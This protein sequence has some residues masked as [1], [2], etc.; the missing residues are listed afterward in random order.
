[1]EDDASSTKARKLTSIAGT[2]LAEV[3][4]AKF[5]AAWLLLVVVPGVLLGLAPLVLSAWLSR[6]TDKVATLSGLGSLAVLVLII[7]IGIHGLRPLLRLVERSFWALQAI[8]VQPIYALFREVLS[9]VT[10]SLL[11]ANADQLRRTQRRS[12]TALASGLLSSAVGIGLVLLVWSHTRWEGTFADLMAPV[13]LIIPALA[14]TVAIG[15]VYLAAASMLWAIADATMHQPQELEMAG[16]G[17]DHGKTWHIAHLS[18]LHTVGEPYGFRL[19]SGRAGPQGNSRLARVFEQLSRQEAQGRLDVVLI[20]GDMTDTGRSAEWIEFLDVLA[21]HRQLSERALILPGNH[22]VNVV[23]RSNPARLELPTSPMKQLRQMRTLSAMV[24]V[25]G[26]RVRVFDRAYKRLGE[27][28]ADKVKP[29]RQLIADLADQNRVL[30]STEL[31][32]LWVDCFP[33]ILPPESGHGLGIVILNSNSESNFSFTNALGLLPWED[34]QVVRTVMDQYP[35][36]GWIVALHHHLME[37]PMP[38]SSLSERIGTALINGNWVVRQLEPVGQRMMVMHGHRHIDWIG[39]AGPLKII[40]APSPVM[41]A[42]D[43][44][45]TYFYIHEV[46]VSSEGTLDLIQHNRILVPGTDVLM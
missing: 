26:H 40:S 44:D 39:H 41:E 27:T 1:V 24:A 4:L 36:A 20:T 11:P 35:G 23:D 19:E 8:A 6:V 43:R 34:V 13:Q 21:R 28:L 9:Q 25:Q 15:G 5:L 30:R 17:S 7:A 37:Y 29:F 22:D 12:S 38:V 31:S 32:R 3:S 14:N 42:R 46:G 10:E 16:A 18:D 45:E 2:I 33:Q